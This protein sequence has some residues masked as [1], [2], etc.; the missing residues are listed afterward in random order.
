[1]KKLIKRMRRLVDL[2]DSGL[3]NELARRIGKNLA[4]TD[5]SPLHYEAHPILKGLHLISITETHSLPAVVTARG[6]TEAW[7]FTKG[8]RYIAR[9]EKEPGYSSFSRFELR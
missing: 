7:T 1:M 3:T 2:S 8:E 6:V 4:W 9:F 5:N